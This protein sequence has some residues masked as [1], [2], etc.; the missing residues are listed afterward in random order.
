MVTN[1]DQTTDFNKVKGIQTY[2]VLKIMLWVKDSA[3]FDLKHGFYASTPTGGSQVPGIKDPAQIMSMLYV[4]A[5]H[6]V[7][8]FKNLSSTYGSSMVLRV[9][10]SWKRCGDL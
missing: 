10:E 5:G 3:L 2:A 9:V 6:D 4:H 8:A 7:C 1:Y